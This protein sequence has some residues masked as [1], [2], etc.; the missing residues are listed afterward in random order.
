MTAA[1]I[2]LATFVAAVGIAL[3]GPASAQDFSAGFGGGDGV[4]A[5][6]KLGSLAYSGGS[7]DRADTVFD[8]HQK[9]RIGGSLLPWLEPYATIKPWVGS[10]RAPD[11]T[12]QGVGGVLM[13]VPIGAFTFTP[14]VGAGYVSRSVRDS[15]G[16]MEVRSQLEL[17]YEFENKARVSL[18]FSHI[19]GA[20]QT[21]G[22]PDD[23]VVGFTYRMPI[24]AIFGN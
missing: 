11:G 22:R 15:S 13:D 4:L 8:L 7:L 16:A 12:M 21:V 2:V 19:T 20:G 3:A 6:W 1:R 9:F 24:G 14:S 23:D 17:G 18:G 10:E 5:D